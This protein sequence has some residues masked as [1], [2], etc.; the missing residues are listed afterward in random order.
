[1]THL[2]ISLPTYATAEIF[3]LNLSDNLNVVKEKLT[4]TNIHYKYVE[5]PH[6]YYSKKL[7]ELGAN[8]EVYRNTV[9]VLSHIPQNP[10]IKFKGSLN[11][12]PIVDYTK[13]LFR[14]KNILEIQITCN[15]N[16][17]EIQRMLVALLSKY[18]H[19]YKHITEKATEYYEW[20][21]PQKIKKSYMKINLELTHQ[22]LFAKALK[23]KQSELNSN[24][25]DDLIRRYE[26]NPYHASITYKIIEEVV[27]DSTGF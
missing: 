19:N 8:K 16:K 24:T 12:N 23:K 26:E 6:E 22:Y 21:I 11:G 7:K 2:L 17:E 18:G 25:T 20:N 1:V 3:G 5:K 10:F 14:S 9:S 15:G 4:A 27:S 13:I